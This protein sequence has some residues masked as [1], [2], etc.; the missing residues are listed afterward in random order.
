MNEFIFTKK[1]PAKYL[2]HLAF[3]LAHTVNY[4]SINMKPSVISGIHEPLI[5]A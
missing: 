4:R 5:S 3:W 1:R 2:R